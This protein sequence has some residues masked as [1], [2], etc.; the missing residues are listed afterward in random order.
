V[1]AV[2]AGCDQNLLDFVE[3]AEL[4]M[5]PRVHAVVASQAQVVGEV[6]GRLGKTAAVVLEVEL[7]EEPFVLGD[8][9]P[10]LPPVDCL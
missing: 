7:A 5:R 8:S 6:D 4:P 9:F 1:G 10:R 2:V 3:E